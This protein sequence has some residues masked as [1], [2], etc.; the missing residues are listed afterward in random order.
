M[1]QFEPHAALDGGSDGL[2]A[3]RALAEL[4]PRILVQGGHALLE[5]GFGQAQSVGTLFQELEITRLAPDLSGT[6]RCV[7]LR[8]P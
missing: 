2:T 7:I 3:H 1:S 8:K 4:L 6:P 5:I